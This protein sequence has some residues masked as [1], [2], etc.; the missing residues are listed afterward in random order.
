MQP[1]LGVRCTVV[2]LLTA[3]IALL[4]FFYHLGTTPANGAERALN[5]HVPYCVA[6][7]NNRRPDRHDGRLVFPV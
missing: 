3:I 6:T 5:S 7:S 1:N 2:N 4:H